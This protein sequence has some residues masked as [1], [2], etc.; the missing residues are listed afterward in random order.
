MIRRAMNFVIDRT[1]PLEAGLGIVF[2]VWL[3]RLLSAVI[4][5]RDL[6]DDWSFALLGMLG[7]GVCFAVLLRVLSWI[8]GYGSGV[9]GVASTVIKEALNIRLVGVVVLILVVM[10]PWMAVTVASEDRLSYRIQAYLEYSLSL[11]LVVMSLMTV[12]LG[13]RT[14]SKEVEDKQIMIVGVKPVSRPMYLVGK[15]LGVM[16]LNVLLVLVS[17]GSVYW[18]T[19]GYL[20][21]QKAKTDFETVYVKDGLLAGNVT[22][23][24]RPASNLMQLAEQRVQERVKREMGDVLELGRLE[25]LEKNY[26]DTTDQNLLMKWGVDRL[27][28]SV[29]QEVMDQWMS[30]KANNRKTYVFEG[31]QDV[32]RLKRSLQIRYK[33]NSS[34]NPRSR[35]ITVVAEIAGQQ[36]PFSITL[37]REEV[38]IVPWQSVDVDGRL[39][40]TV[41]NVDAY[42]GPVEWQTLHFSATH[43]MEL[44]YPKVS[45]TTNYVRAFFLVL[46]K[47]G[48]LTI[49]SL[50]FATFLGFPVAVL[51]AVLICVAASFSDFF[52]SA[53][54]DIRRINE[55]Q[56]GFDIQLQGLAGFLGEIISGIMLEYSQYKPVANLVDGRLISWSHVVSC[57]GWIGVLW[58]GV[59]GLIGVFVFRSREL[60]RVQV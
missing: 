17:M 44:F 42:G 49:M 24:P 59:T 39:E 14:L 56:T 18:F 48:F 10:L 52:L 34:K 36:K 23:Q 19:A 9:V 57:L 12:L 58:T 32:R 8:T 40:F 33:A 38:I 47:L 4:A 16:F 55:T 30:I 20:A 50:T 35:E 41:I 29:Q 54:A 3:F 11:V 53:A 46:I 5:G 37:S 51:S 13:C 28:R 60:A 22:V 2:F 45:F 7:V 6:W 31:L 15:W 43:G 25:A 21:N 26:G 27:R 1:G